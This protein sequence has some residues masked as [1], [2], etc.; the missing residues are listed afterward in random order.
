MT[1]PA[2]TLAPG[3]LL[4]GL[5]GLAFLAF[6]LSLAV[7]PSGFGFGPPGAAGSLIFWEIRLPRA[8]LGALVGATLGLAG[9]ALQGYLRNPLAEPSLIGISG[10]AALGAVLA[11][12][13]GITQALAL[14]LPLGGLLGACIAMLAVVALAGLHGG[15]ITLI[16]AGLAVSAT[17][18]ALIS[19]A[20]NLSR[21]PFASIEMV[22]WMMGS[23]ADRSL[24]QAWLSGPLML[25]GMGLL[26]LLGRALDALSLGEDAAVSLGIDAR[27]TRLTLV[28]GT[29]LSVGAATAVTGII[30]F[31]GLL[32]PHALRPLT[33]HRP[34]LLLPASL[35]GGAILVLLADVA[36]RLVEPWADLRIGVLTALFGAPFFIWLVL[37]TRRELAP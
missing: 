35:F 31:V 22:Y 29:A 8:L 2:A 28:A 26:L 15:P 1:A 5:A 12:H 34:G 14:A 10:G 27:R 37:K 16:L 32:V 9:A 18:T 11:I 13:L 17:T 24:T 7:G 23:L 36:L 6:A 20:L 21:N 25:I 33:G 3:R 4:A 30:G 19:L